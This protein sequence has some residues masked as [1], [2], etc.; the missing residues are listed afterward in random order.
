[1]DVLEI[2]T[3]NSVFEDVERPNRIVIDLDPGERVTWPQVVQ[4]ARTVRKALEALDL[5]SYVKTTGGRGLH[6][7]VPLAPLADW[8][9]CLEFSRGLAVAIEAADPDLYTTQ[10]AKVG[11]DRKILIDYLRN[12][13]TNTSIAAFSSRARPHATVSVPISWDEL[14]T[15]LKPDAFTVR[16]VPA[17]LTRLVADP[18]AG[19]WKSRQKLTRQRVKA[20]RAH[21]NGR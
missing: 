14:R 18:W 5:E 1:M 17:R 21:A 13:R 11:R 8:A 12:N 10:F 6:V 2:H 20:L 4:A 15:S 16:T 9:E 3:W 7:V 19:Y